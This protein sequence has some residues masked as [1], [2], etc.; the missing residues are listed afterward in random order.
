MKKTIEER[1]SIIK[2]L[3]QINI[4]S[5][6]SLLKEIIISGNTIFGVAMEEVLLRLIIYQLSY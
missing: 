5:I 2:E 4:D 1:L 6:V 3:D